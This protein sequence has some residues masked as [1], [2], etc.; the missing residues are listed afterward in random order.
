MDRVQLACN[1]DNV[2]ACLKLALDVGLGLEVQTFAYPAALDD[3]V[4]A[5]VAKYKARL[6]GFPGYISMHGAFIDMTSASL[7]PKV[8][9]VA[10]E[11]YTHNLNIAA[12]LGARLVVFH[13]NY[14]THIRTPEFRAEWTELQVKFWEPMA[15][16][17]AS[18]QITIAVEN[19]W[20]YEP[21]IISNVLKQIDSPWLVACL[22]TSH[23]HLYG[24]TPLD[25]WL[26]AL[27]DCIRYVHLNNTAGTDDDHYG[28]DDGVM[29]YT[30][31]LPKLRALPRPPI[32]AL[33]MLKV[34]AMRRSLPLFEL[35]PDVEL[36]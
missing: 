33:E 31:V 28:L 9:A 1:D 7:D 6:R 26:A 3:D 8:A 24:E 23:A 22:D 14:L 19:M 27:G 16:L 20:E 21:T 12:E 35:T 15:E 10:R 4:N 18:L 36:A 2:D 29:D 13:A 32:F 25:A 17:A 5:R 30:A 11:R 34:D